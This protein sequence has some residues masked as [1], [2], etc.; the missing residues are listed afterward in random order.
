M[1]KDVGSRDLARMAD[2]LGND[3]LNA[4]LGA[5]VAK[6]DALLQFV[7]VRLQQIAAA[8]QAELEALHHKRAWFLDLTR[9]HKGFGMPDP[10][11]WHKV[12]LT[13]RGA[14]EALCAGRLG[15]AVR[16]VG[17]AAEQDRA[18]FASLPKQVHLPK[19]TEKRAEE[20]EVS[21]SVSAEEGAPVAAAPDAL[22]LADRI[23][24]VAESPGNVP[25][26]A[27]RTHKW[28]EVEEEEG[29]PEDE[30]KKKA[31]A[32]KGKATPA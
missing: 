26:T 13:Y 30:K 16:R 12:A 31:G 3:K 8:Q 27:L 19:N 5:A 23:I 6:R 18:T 9:K 11:R 25:G 4:T 29:E 14:L 2:K 1:L 22:R 15:E 32:K 21:A 10:A 7:E 28:W 24:A 17:E 20:P